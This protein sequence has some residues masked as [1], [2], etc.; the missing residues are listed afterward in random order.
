M[1]LRFIFVPICAVLIVSCCWAKASLLRLE[2]N[3]DDTIYVAFTEYRP[4]YMEIMKNPDSIS[5]KARM[6]YV[7]NPHESEKLQVG[8]YIYSRSEV[9]KNYY[10]RIALYIY[11]VKKDTIYMCFDLT[12]EQA[13]KMHW[14]VRYPE[15]GYLSLPLDEIAL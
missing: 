8:D 4:T 3:S 13:E 2:N 11:S 7:L 1:N 5:R 6:T 12:E 10:G 15:D 14:V 9:W